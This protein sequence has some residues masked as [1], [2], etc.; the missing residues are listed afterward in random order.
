MN[1]PGDIIQR[2]L[3]VLQHWLNKSSQVEEQKLVQAV[4]KTFV[5]ESK[6]Y[7]LK[8]ISVHEA[9]MKPVTLTQVVP[10]QAIDL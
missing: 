3:E 7:N 6:M 8:H 4:R 1:Y 5:S 2:K 10:M 9:S